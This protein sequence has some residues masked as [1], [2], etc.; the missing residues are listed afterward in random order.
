MRYVELRPAKQSSAGNQ[1]HVSRVCGTGLLRR[2]TLIYL[3]L[4]AAR[5]DGALRR[6]VRRGF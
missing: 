4:A 2:Y 5:K 1:R 3:G 6:D